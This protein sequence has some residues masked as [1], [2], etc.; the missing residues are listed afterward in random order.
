MIEPVLFG[1]FFGLCV[2]VG[3]IFALF[4]YRIGIKGPK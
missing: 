2:G 4:A 1:L 3:A